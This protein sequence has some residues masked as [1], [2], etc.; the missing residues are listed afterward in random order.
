MAVGLGFLA[1]ILFT[2]L[3]N[4]FG[5]CRTRCSRWIRRRRAAKAASATPSSA[6]C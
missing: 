1:W 5:A 2:L 6:A 3:V 4:G